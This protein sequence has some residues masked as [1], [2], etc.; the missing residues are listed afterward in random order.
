MK[1]EI[2]SPP[3]GHTV[4]MEEIFKEAQQLQKE[5]TGYRRALHAMAEVGFDIKNTRRFIRQTL[6]SFGCKTENC[7]KAGVVATIGQGEKYILLRADADGLP[8]EEKTGLKYAS[9]TGNMH[10]CGHDMHVSML[11]GA[12]KLLKER[13]E[14]LPCAVRLLF[15]PAEEILQGAKDC[16]DAGVLQ[17]VRAA[18]TLHVMTDVELPVG[19]VVFPG[20]G[21]SA[22]AADYFKVTVKGRSC[23]GSAP[24][25]GVDALIPTSHI[26][27]GL[28]EIIARELPSSSLSVLTVGR[29]QGGVAGNAIA[30]YA[31]AEGTLRSFDEEERA[32]IK[33]RIKEISDGIAKAFRAKA[34]TEFTSG[35]PTLV[36]D[37]ELSKRMYEQAKRLFNADMVLSSSQLGGGTTKKSGG[38]EDF[39]HFSQKVPS[40]MLALAAGEPK[41]GCIH[42]LHHPKTK[43]DEQA[44]CTGSALYALFALLN[45]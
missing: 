32:F 23:H 17:G 5:L 11:L 41:N 40:L 22:P 28:Q 12:A 31:E 35:C 43:F 30:D 45:G 26:L 10:A 33:R 7:G 19:T 42:P 39:A 44:L 36:N 14:K 9:K 21:V 34:K 1:K 25:N 13:E 27:L 15:Q 38:S 2:K 29:L 20:G 37:E 24:Q 3:L 6:E 18:F 4:F 16:I 8:I